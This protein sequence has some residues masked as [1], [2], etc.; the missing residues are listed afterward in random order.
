MDQGRTRDW[1]LKVKLYEAVRRQRTA[2]V[3][4][5]KDDIT[6]AKSA[7]RSTIGD[8]RLTCAHRIRKEPRWLP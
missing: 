4:V 3:I 1:L 2:S 5:L 8:P 7:R 6:G